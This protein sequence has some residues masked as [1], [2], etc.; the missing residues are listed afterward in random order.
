VVARTDGTQ[1]L[2]DVAHPARAGDVLVIYCVGLGAVSPPVAA[3]AAAPLS[4]LS[5]T[6]N[7]TTVTIGGVAA[8][9]SFAG[10]TPGFAGL[11]QVNVQVPSGV[12]PGS[13]IPLV[14]TVDG[15]PSVGS[16]IA[17]Q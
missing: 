15:H 6:V 11:Y 7:P 8:Q 10:L 4:Q 14:L 12:A 13:A 9:P 17:V 16:T 5:S 3:G 2:N 1:F